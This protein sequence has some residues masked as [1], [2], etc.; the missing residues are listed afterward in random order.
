MAIFNSYVSLPEGSSNFYVMDENGT[1]G[2]GTAAL[3][4]FGAVENPQFSMSQAMACRNGK[5]G[6][7]PKK[8]QPTNVVNRKP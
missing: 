4:I 3:E 5:V 6:E 2:D 7:K 1:Q 8:K